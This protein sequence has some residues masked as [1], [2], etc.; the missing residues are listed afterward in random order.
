M[1]TRSRTSGSPSPLRG[2]L[3]LI[4][5]LLAMA[6]MLLSLGAIGWLVDFGSDRGLEAR[7]QSRG[8][9]LAQAKMA[10]LEAGVI[11]LQGGGSGTFDTDPEWSWSVASQQQGPPNLYQVTVTVSRDFRGRPFDV[12]LSQLLFDPTLM[13]S[14]AQAEQPT[15]ADVQNAEANTGTT[16]GS[17]P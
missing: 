5:V 2:G 13:G 11:S 12:S 8:T 10:E 3:S 16:G 17:S 6:I 15:D 4:E 9:R 14:A 7:F 1:R